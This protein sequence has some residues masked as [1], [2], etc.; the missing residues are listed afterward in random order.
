M[1]QALA[2]E[3]EIISIHKSAEGTYSLAGSEFSFANYGLR[4]PQYPVSKA[5]L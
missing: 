1:R 3:Q 2:A 4:A 5:L